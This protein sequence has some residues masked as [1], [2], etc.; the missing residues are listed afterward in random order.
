MNCLNSEAV[1]LYSPLESFSFAVSA[2]GIDFSVAAPH[3]VFVASPGGQQNPIMIIKSSASQRGS[4]EDSPLIQDPL[5]QRTYHA[6]D[7]FLAPV[8]VV[9]TH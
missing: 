3:S 6:D 2:M 4:K 7:F 5:N 8:V 9:I 1:L